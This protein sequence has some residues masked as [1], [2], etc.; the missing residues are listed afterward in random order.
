MTITSSQLLD[1]LKYSHDRKQHRCF[2]APKALHNYRYFKSNLA[3]RDPLLLIFFLSLP[4]THTH[5]HTRT[6]MHIHTLSESAFLQVLILVNDRIIHSTVETSD[7]KSPFI[8]LFH[9][10]YL[11]HQQVLTTFSSVQFSHSVVTPTPCDPIDCSTPGFPVHH[12]LPELAQ[13][14]VH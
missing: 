8:T 9:I 14:L 12:Q 5:T 6:H 2:N 7:L 3:P 13:T 4:F 11:I 1:D 10:P